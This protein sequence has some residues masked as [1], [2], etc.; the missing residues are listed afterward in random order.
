MIAARTWNLPS[1]S[2]SVLST[3]VNC[4]AGWETSARQCEWKFGWA[5]GKQAWASGILYRLY[6]RLPSSGECQKIFS[7]P[8]CCGLTHGAWVKY[9]YVCIYIYI[10]YIYMSVDW[11]IIGWGNGSPYMWHPGITGIDA[12]TLSTGC[13]RTNFLS[14][15]IEIFIQESN[16]KMLVKCHPF[17]SGHSALHCDMR[18]VPG[19]CLNI[20][21]SSYQYRDPHVKDKTVLRPSY[22]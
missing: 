7:F 1:Y 17:C 8:A 16:L 10:Y 6:K 4:C 11:V 2:V 20:K 9:T 14:Q 18:L 15:N 19:G 12:D 22:L 21:M 5:S 13:L 3:F